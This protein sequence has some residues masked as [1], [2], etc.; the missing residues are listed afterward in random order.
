MRSNNHLIARSILIGALALLAL[1]VAARP[2][3]AIP[4]FAQRYQL[5]CATCHSV[6]PELNAFGEY[7]R[8][9]NY[10][11]PNA[12]IHGTTGVAFRY[13]ME[14]EKTPVA[15]T[16]RFTPGGV[17]LSSADIG[18]V[19][20]FLHYNLGAGGGPSAVYLGFLSTYDQHSK[21]LYRAGLFELPLEH[22]PAQRLDDLTPYGYEA[23]KVGL[24]DLLLTAPRL[25]LEVEKKTG[26]VQLAFTGALAEFKGAA[27]GGRPIATG[28]STHAAAPEFGLFASAP[29]GTTFTLGGDLLGGVR[30]IDVT[31]RR[32]FTDTYNRR[33]LFARAQR[34]R[35]ELL[36]H[37]WWGNDGNAD[38]LGS[39]LGSSGGYVRFRYMPDPHAYLAMR[40]D[41]AAAPF[42]TRS[43]V[44][45]AAALVGG[46]ARLLIER[47][48]P[49]G[50]LGSGTFG[51]AVT[52]GFPWPAKL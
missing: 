18:K 41:A 9:H 49:L 42:A 14:Y 34:G 4:L 46:H 12:R 29:L 2:A 43:V 26:A 37:Q 35:F 30:A 11:I 8:A 20:A 15:G 39:A 52:V 22:S 44:F 17:L 47:R 5:T 50:G 38:G 7:F 3:G 16:R 23:T 28:E 6:L 13:Q 27:Y 48:Q 51:G 25:G 31:G 1:I 32:E 45:Y 10:R 21:S 19:T 33:G 36:A 40:Y 24:N